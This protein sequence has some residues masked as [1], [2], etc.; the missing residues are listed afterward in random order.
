MTTELEAVRVSQCCRKPESEDRENH[1]SLCGEGSGFLLVEQDIEVT[2]RMAVAAIA[3]YG[4][5]H[6]EEKGA[7]AKKQSLSNAILKPYLAANQGETLYDGESGL[8]ARL[9]P[10]GAPRWLDTKGIEDEL[11][12]W[13]LRQGLLKV[14]LAELDKM[15]KGKEPSFAF[16]N[17][18]TRIRRGGEGEPRLSV[19]KRESE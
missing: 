6:E 14:D 15:A 16:I 13:A 19:S 2:Q 12:L 9:T 3:A 8:E 10:H 18:N 17:F 11:V 7:K 4:K 1:C 5:A